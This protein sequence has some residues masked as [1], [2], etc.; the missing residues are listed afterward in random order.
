MVKRN[1]IGLHAQALDQRRFPQRGLSCKGGG[2]KSGF[3][4]AAVLSA[5]ATQTFVVPAEAYASAIPF[6]LLRG[7]RNQGSEVIEEMRKNGT[8]CKRERERERERECCCF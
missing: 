5:A 3:G 1:L 6:G 2:G 4:A 8:T 7:A